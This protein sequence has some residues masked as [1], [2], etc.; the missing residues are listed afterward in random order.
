LRHPETQKFRSCEGSPSTAPHGIKRASYFSALI[1]MS[2]TSFGARMA[3]LMFWTSIPGVGSS[4][5]LARPRP[6][7]TGAIIPLSPFA[8]QDRRID[9]PADR[10]A[11]ASPAEVPAPTL[12]R[13]P[14]RVL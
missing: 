10:S 8:E 4:A 6:S 5:A 12:T 7:R 2:I 13:H 14:Q 9:G 1:A 3:A 11:G